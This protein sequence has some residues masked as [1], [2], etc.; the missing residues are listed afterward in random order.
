MVVG[1]H[2]GFQFFGQNAQFLENSRALPKILYGSLHCL[3]K[4]FQIIKKLFHKNQF[5]INV[6]R[7]LK[8]TRENITTIVDNK[9]LRNSVCQN[10]SLR[11]HIDSHKKSSR[12]RKI[13]LTNSGNLKE[14]LQHRVEGGQKPS[15]LASEC[16]IIYCFS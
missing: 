10:I 12:S 1:G 5:Y 16:P 8:K 3:I 11:D 4:N 15:K 14:L 7:H 6:A 9:I 13:G 2:Q